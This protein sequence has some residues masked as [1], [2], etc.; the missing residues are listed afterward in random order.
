MRNKLGTLCMIMG[1]VLVLAALSLFFWNRQEAEKAGQ[2]SEQVLL[3]LIDKIV[4]KKDGSGDGIKEEGSYPDPYDIEMT[5]VEIDGVFY[6]GYVS[7]PVLNLEL[8]VISE[9]NYSRLMI[10]PCR[11]AGSTKT[12]D[13]VI[14]GHNYT[15]HFGSLH[16]L[17]IGDTVIFTDMDGIVVHY[18]V[19]S[20]EVLEPTAVE[21]MTAGEYDLTL[22]T[23]TYG[24]ASRITVR[25]DQ[26]D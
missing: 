10:A 21:E 22:F 7:I 20:V 13:L 4:E 8:P 12:G 16:R 25:C 2:A 18:E 9:W 23:C 5:E 26:V 6:I 24:G 14:A 3:Q 19:M 15:R 1:T 17:H 11:Y